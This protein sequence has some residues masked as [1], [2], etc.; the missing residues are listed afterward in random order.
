MCL[1]I[2]PK[3]FKKKTLTQGPLFFRSYPEDTWIL[4]SNFNNA[5]T[6][7]QHRFTLAKSYVTCNLF[8]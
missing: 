5:Q 7:V 8:V 1:R 3:Q 4:K 6:T 2:L